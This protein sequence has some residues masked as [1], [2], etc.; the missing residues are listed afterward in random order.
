MNNFINIIKFNKNVYLEIDFD[1]GLKQH[2]KSN[3]KKSLILKKIWKKRNKKAIT[4]EKSNWH[5]SNI[6]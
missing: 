6:K 1:I 2:L 3:F 5:K 4:F